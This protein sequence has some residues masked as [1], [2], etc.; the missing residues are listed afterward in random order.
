M[1][2]CLL[3]G[4]CVGLSDL[5]HSNYTQKER[6]REE[7]FNKKKVGKLGRRSDV[8][9]VTTCRMSTYAETTQNFKLYF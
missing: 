6:V 1:A 4:F 8:F 5:I 9:V 7:R 3:Q 2:I